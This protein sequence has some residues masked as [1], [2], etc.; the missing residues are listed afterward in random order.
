MI[1][2]ISGYDVIIDDDDYER[3]SK[4][5]W[6]HC[7]KPT[8]TCR[9]AHY[10]RNDSKVGD[11]PEVGKFQSLH[12]YIMGCVKGDGKIVDHIN[13]NTLDNRKSNL[14]ICTPIENS[15]NMGKMRHNKAGYKG[16]SRTSTKNIR[17]Q[18]SICINGSSIHIG[19][20]ATK[21]EAAEAY[22]CVAIYYNGEYARLNFP[23]KIYTE[24]TIKSI[25]QSIENREPSANQYRGIEKHSKNGVWVARIRY[26]K[27]RYYL[28]SY[29]SPEEAAKA[30]DRKA[31]ELL[32]DDAILNFQKENYV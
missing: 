20:Y 4:Y 32:G 30:Y 1:L 24:D 9:G 28:G 18:A 14:R 16:V 11:P 27:K 12:R 2:K 5:S 19:T 25:V 31:I 10:F 21:I 26:N 3:I 6:H 23:D 8:D 22:D 13:G 17:W 29:K 15:K 7:S